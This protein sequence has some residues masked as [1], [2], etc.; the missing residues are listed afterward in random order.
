MKEYPCPKATSGT[1]RYGGNKNYNYGFV[2]GTASFCRHPSQKYRGS[3]GRF[4]SDISGCPLTTDER[5]PNEP[6]TPTQEN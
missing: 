1:C 3:A 2:S 5:S 4:V 6:E